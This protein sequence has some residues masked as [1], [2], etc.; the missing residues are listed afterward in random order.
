MKDF[1]KKLSERTGEFGNHYRKYR[2][3]VEK[4]LSTLVTKLEAH[5][6]RDAVH[7]LHPGYDF[8]NELSIV[9]ST[10]QGTEEKLNFIGTYFALHF[11]L[12]NRYAVDQLKMDVLALRADR[13][14]IYK[15]F[16]LAVGNNFRMLTAEYIKELLDIFI[17]RTDSPDFVILGVGT[18]SDQD[19][20][21]VGIIDDGHGD[22]MKFNRAIAHISQEM[23]K[24]AITFHFHLSEHIGDNYYSASINEFKKALK[25]EIKDFVIINEM[26]SAAVIN[27]SNQLFNKYRKEIIDRYFYHQESD[28]RYHEGYLRGITG[29]VHSLLARPIS[30]TSIHFKEDG[31]RAIKSIICAQKTVFNIDQVNAWAIIEKLKTVDSKNNDNYNALERS[32]TFFEIFRY[33]YQLF[34]TQDEEI[35]LDDNALENIGRVAKILG[36]KNLGRCHAEE[37]ILVHFYEHIQNIRKI[38]PTLVDDIKEHLRLTSRFTPMMHSSYPGNIAED[39]IEEFRFFK[40]T[41]FWHD[42]LDNFK[43]ED[44]VLRFVEALNSLPPKK[45]KNIIKQYFELFRYDLYSLIYLITILGKHK[46][47]FPVF[48]ELNV[49]LLKNV[50]AMPGVV[51]NLAYVFNN[52][53]VLVNRYM[54][55]N[56]DLALN[57]YLR[58]FE[59]KIFEKDIADIVNDMVTLIGIHLSSS[60]FFKRFIM[61]ILDKYPDSIRLLESPLQLQEFADGIYSDINSMP[62]FQARK[63]RLGDYYDCEM[64]RVGIKTLSGATVEET[65]AEFTEFSDRYMLTLFDLCRYDVDS[66]Y[67]KRLITDDLFAVF[68]AG[69]HAREQAFDDD[70]DILVLLNSK[71]PEILKYCNKIITKMNGEIIKRGTIPHH[72]FT[73]YFGRFVIL[74]EDVEQLLAEERDD[75]FIEKSQMLGARLIIGSHRFEEEFHRRIVKPYIFDRKQ[76]YISQMTNEIMSRHNSTDEKIMEIERDIKE[77]V[78]G[79]RDV[80]MMMLILKAK[81]E[82]TTPVNSQLF[83]CIA[84]DHKNL[85][86]DIQNMAKAFSFLKTLRDTYRITA[87][88]SDIIITESLD[89]AKQVMGYQT[90]N[91]LYRAFQR[92]KREVKKSIANL[93]AKIK[94]TS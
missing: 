31:L 71:D 22:R 12:H 82:I 15:K 54:A 17:D 57:S 61:R 34:I 56:S 70:Y 58:I 3:A 30:T 93:L 41:S 68:A 14:S 38:I 69:G 87:G 76:E 66:Q 48:E 6:R 74:L 45:R 86:K 88:A 13:L 39:F 89:G 49:H 73:D 28:N 53:P 80:E 11:L 75:I 65:N 62:T 33:L 23:L 37:H 59:K 27:G 46:S 10:A 85:S 78:G 20:I 7:I 21:D 50:E 83:D 35:V 51:R 26:L 44:F 79:L 42:I 84:R 4:H 52:F 91:E 8:G 64:M 29:E 92:T 24:F 90:N 67:K 32:L 72:R 2:Q 40:G 5:K 19:D 18:K 94:L 1:I 55:L 60:K 16:M 25:H 63:E 77:G 43:I 47:S 9:A 81:Y 36:Y